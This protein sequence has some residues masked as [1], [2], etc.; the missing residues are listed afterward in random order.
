MW[1]EGE[2]WLSSLIS[3]RADLTRGDLRGLY[4]GWLLGAQ[5]G[6]LDD[7]DTEPP[8]PP[9]LGELSGPLEDL[10]EFLRLDSDLLH[11]AAGTSESLEEAGPKPKEVRAWVATLPAGEKDD[12]FTRLVLNQDTNLAAILLQRFI[13]EHE[14]AGDRGAR[15]QGRRTV[16]DLLH[17]AEEYGKERERLA[18]IKLAEEKKRQAQEA[19]SARTRHLDK[20]AGQEPRLW[21]EVTGLITAKQPKDYDQAVQL[22][23][24]LRDLAA[25]KGNSG[26]FAARLEA[27]RAEH[28]R[29]STFIERLR[30]AGL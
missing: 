11:I 21:D 24:D 2:D 30:R 8:V 20:I 7:E 26:M 25:R 6:E 13:K 29:K 23:D 19:A 15:Q 5:N 14:A 12:L 27:L 28:A 22:L 9:G 4:L 18:A 17:A 16:A 3:I 1:V 10:V